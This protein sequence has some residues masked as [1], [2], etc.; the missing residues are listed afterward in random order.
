MRG[1]PCPMRCGAFLLDGNSKSRRWPWWAS[2]RS[3]VTRERPSGRFGQHRAARRP[4]WGNPSELSAILA[5]FCLRANG[6]RKPGIATLLRLAARPSRWM[7]N[8]SCCGEPDN[9]QHYCI[10]KKSSAAANRGCSSA[11][12]RTWQS[13]LAMWT[14]N[15]V[16]SRQRTGQTLATLSQNQL[17]SSAH[18]PAS[19]SLPGHSLRGCLP[20]HEHPRRAVAAT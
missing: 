12:R 7:L 18:L 11:C 17:V 3:L 10:Y 9:A 19:P 4:G 14:K 5:S 8:Y 20:I 1:Q 2:V 6:G 16:T 15:T 13:K